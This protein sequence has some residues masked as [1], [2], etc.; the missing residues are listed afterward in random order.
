MKLLTKILLVILQEMTRI[1][2]CIFTLSYYIK[3]KKPIIFLK[4]GNR[5]KGK[6]LR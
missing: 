4:S 5:E 6:R 1:V 2:K 3:K